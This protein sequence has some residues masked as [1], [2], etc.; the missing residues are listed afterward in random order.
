MS[1]RTTFV[2]VSQNI[3]LVALL[4][5]WLIVPKKGRI[6]EQGDTQQ[7]LTDPQHAYT[8]KLLNNL[9]RMPDVDFL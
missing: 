8:R 4:C 6:V 2:M 5:Q 1:E 7:L 3:A 9:P